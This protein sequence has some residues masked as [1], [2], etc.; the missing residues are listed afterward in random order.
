MQTCHPLPK[1]VIDEFPQ[2]AARSIYDRP[3]DDPAQRESRTRRMVYVSRAMGW[4]TC[5]VMMVGHF[6]LLL[7]SMLDVFQGQMGS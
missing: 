4:N 3:A 6:N 7:D 2:V 5:S 1:T